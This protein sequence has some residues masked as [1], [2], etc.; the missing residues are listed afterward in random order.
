MDEIEQLVAEIP[1]PRP[2]RKKSKEVVVRGRGRPAHEPT[3]ITRKQVLHFCGMGMTQKQ[4]SVLLG[5][6]PITLMKHYRRELDI[7]EAQMNVNVANN[8]YTI[9]TDPAHKG[10]VQAAIFWMKTRGRW[11]ETSRVEHTGAD[12]EAIK[13]ESKKAEV[14]DSSK[15]SPEHREALREIIASAIAKQAQ[16]DAHKALKDV[17]Q[18]YEEAE[19]EEIDEDEDEE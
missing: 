17:E 2:K 12:G 1:D 4:I 11:R 6:A 19:Y 15:L 13:T 18:N 14:I 16:D 10:G 5:I 8:L 9:A 3:E 7:G